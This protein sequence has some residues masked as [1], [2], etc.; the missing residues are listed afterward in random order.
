V[1]PDVAVCGFDAGQ[2]FVRVRPTYMLNGH[3]LTLPQDYV[4]MYVVPSEPHKAP[5]RDVR[6]VVPIQLTTDPWVN[7]DGA[8]ASTPNDFPYSSDRKENFEASP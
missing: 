5:F 2:F 7:S 3:E 1:A 8:D 6:I 4:V